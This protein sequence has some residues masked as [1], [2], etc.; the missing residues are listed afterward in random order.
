MGFLAA[1][2]F[3]LVVFSLGVGSAY[4]TVMGTLVFWAT[5]FCLGLMV[6]KYERIKN[7]Y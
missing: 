7:V 2:D 6:S 1:T 3:F 5:C 4:G